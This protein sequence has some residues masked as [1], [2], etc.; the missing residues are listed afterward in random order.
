M[1]SVLSGMWSLAIRYG[2]VETN[3]VT[4]TARPKV[5]R[6]AK[7]SL[8]V[9]Q[10]RALL[11]DIRESAAPCPPVIRGEQQ[12][13]ERDVPTVA[14][15]CARADLV[16]VVTMFSATGV[17]MSE[18]LG[19]EWTGV[20]FVA[21]TVR[22]DGKVVRH[23][24]VGLVRV[25]RDDDPKNTTRVLAL[26]DYAVSM[27]RARKLAQPPNERGLVFASTAGTLRDP[28]ALNK[29]WRRVRT[30]LG[31]DWV[32]GHTFRRTVAS[33]L[34]EGKLSARVTADQLGHSSPSMTQ[35]RYMS[36]GTVRHEVADMLN[37]VIESGE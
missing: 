34:D 14:Q 6:S 10:L 11:R 15:Y 5:T 13:A 29:Q 23:R 1:R 31:L 28:D 8:D 35:D 27:L 3:P 24:G 2:V 25:A 37:A 4:H 26:P 16:D 17:R 30:A 12:D 32:T 22:I 9:K 36:R 19:I 18:L 20:D 7:Q 33:V 21:R